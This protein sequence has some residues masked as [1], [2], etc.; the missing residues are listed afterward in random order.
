MCKQN[1]PAVAKEGKLLSQLATD[2]QTPPCRNVSH[3]KLDFSIGLI[4]CRMKRAGLVF[5]VLA[6]QMVLFVSI[7]SWLVELAAESG[8]EQRGGVAFGIT[9]YYGV[10]ILGFVC[11][12]ASMVSVTAQ[13]RTT[14]CLVIAGCLIGWGLWIYPA[15]SSYPIRGTVFLTLGAL[16]LI[17]GS[18]ILLPFLVRVLIGSD[19]NER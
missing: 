9:V 13:K 11:L 7:W 8:R 17:A 12:V 15:L 2:A 19:R 10:F 18:G 3:R 6:I 1:K 5:V 4:S 16:I 14:R